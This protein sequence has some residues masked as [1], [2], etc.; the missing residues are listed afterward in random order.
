MRYIV[1]VDSG[2]THS[3]NVRIGYKVKIKVNKS[4]ADNKHGGKEKAL[5]KAKKWRNQQLKKMLPLM[6]KAYKYD[7]NGQRYWGEGIYQAWDRKKDWEYLRI[8]AHYYDGT[9]LK[10]IKKSFSVSKYGY[11]EAIALA[12]QWRNFKLTGEL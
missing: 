8:Y 6:F 5:I 10:Q 1:R 12:T 4:F 11:D 7:Q 9:K 2:T 3:Y